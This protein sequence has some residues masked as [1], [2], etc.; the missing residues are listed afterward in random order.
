MEIPSLFPQL[1][2]EHSTLVGSRLEIHARA[3]QVWLECP[4]CGIKSCKVHSFY[5]RS[6]RDL[7]L[8]EHPVRLRL[9]VRR[10]FCF[11]STCPRATFAETFPDLLIPKAQRTGRLKTAQGQV[12]VAVGGQ[13][14]AR[15]LEKLH[16]S[17]SPDTVLRTMSALPL[18]ILPSPR[19]VGIDDFA[20]RKGVNYGTV[21]VDLERRHIVDVLPDRSATTVATWLKKH[22]GIEQVARDGSLEYARAIT[23]GAPQAQQIADRWHVLHNLSEYVYNWLGRHRTHLCEPD[24]PLNT[25]IPI[26][27]FPKV[28]QQDIRHVRQLLSR[29]AHRGIRLEQY[30]QVKTLA[31]A[32]KT[33]QSIA[34]TIGVSA[35]TVRRWLK[36]GSFPERKNR[37]RPIQDHLPFIHTRMR[38]NISGRQI[39][40]ELLELDSKITLGMVYHAVYM[41]EHGLESYVFNDAVPL[42]AGQRRYSPQ[43][44]LK[45]LMQNPL[46]RTPQDQARLE[47]LYQTLP[48]S[49]SL[50]HWLTE[51][52]SLFCSDPVL[53]SRGQRLEE[54]MAQAA[55]LKIPEIGRFVRSFEQDRAAIL[56]SLESPWSNGQTEGQVTKLKL[57]KRQRYGRASFGHLRRCAL[58]A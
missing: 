12:G 33:H 18:P 7:P 56:A 23:D 5:L 4:D 41:L 2:V 46:N 3:S 8:S 30:T 14:G 6:P 51:V 28:P 32:G 36:H 40:H 57:I 52:R 22:P 45:L 26:Q 25:P 31:D 11:N 35:K 20:F 21:I 42:P 53:G 29:Q 16:M 54:K 15:L 38:E 49:K 47:R 1:E 48:V 39:H 44:G 13:A 37:R 43:Q 58:L 50:H 34:D 9:R 55:E 19:V 17:T 10:F 27:T 24:L